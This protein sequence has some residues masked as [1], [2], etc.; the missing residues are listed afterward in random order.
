M[1]YGFD[2]HQGD[3]SLNAAETATESPGRILSRTSA[4]CGAATPHTPRKPKSEVKVRYRGGG[5]N[6]YT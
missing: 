3:A 4:R 2:S 5:Q 6:Q 1:Q